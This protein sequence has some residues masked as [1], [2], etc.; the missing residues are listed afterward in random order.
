MIKA[1]LDV[2]SWNPREAVAFG[3]RARRF[4]SK[5]ALSAGETRIDGKDAVEV[6]YLKPQLGRVIVLEVS[7]E[8]EQAA[9]DALLGGL[10]AVVGTAGSMG[11]RL[12]VH[13]V[14]P[15]ESGLEVR[16]RRPKA[17][18]TLG[19]FW[20]RLLQAWRVIPSLKPEYTRPAPVMRLGPSGRRERPRDPLGDIMRRVGVPSPQHGAYREFARELGR[21]LACSDDDREVKHAVAAVLAWAESR[22][23]SSDLLESIAVET[24]VRLKANALP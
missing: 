15:A 24:V 22:G 14:E 4:A 23:L 12:R 2:K 19:D 17:R 11:G 1:A 3:V 18:A 20:L 21:A 9:F 16:S 6:L 10:S 8:D 7:G 5:I 13:V